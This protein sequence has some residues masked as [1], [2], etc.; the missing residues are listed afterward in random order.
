MST[1]ELIAIMG[2]V[3]ES[4]RESFLKE[5]ASRTGQMSDEEKKR[6]QKKLQEQ[7]DKE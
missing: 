3:E 7:Q 5:L 2:Y 4:E 1:Q 6:Y